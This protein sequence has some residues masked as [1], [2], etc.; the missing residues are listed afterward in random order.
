M[1][2]TSSGIG[3]V[4]IAPALV[5]TSVPVSA[6]MAAGP[7]KLIEGSGLTGVST[8]RVAL[9]RLGRARLAREG[10]LFGRIGRGPGIAFAE[11]ADSIVERRIASDEL[12]GH[13]R[14]EQVCSAG[15]S[16]RLGDPCRGQ[17]VVRMPGDAIGA[18]RRD[19]VRADLGDRL[20]DECDGVLGILEVALA[21]AEP[22]D[23]DV[24]HPQL[25]EAGAQLVL[26]QVSEVRLVGV[27]RVDRSL[28]SLSDCED[29]DPT[30]GLDDPGHQAG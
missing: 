14:I 7:T 6:A 11:Q 4:R 8:E 12:V 22:D 19:R 30:A 5:K 27:R 24:V 29:G 20:G 18:E 13:G 9:V 21:I 25:G 1:T 26:A 10:N 16:P 28:L 17:P 3:T 2:A 15:R 23:A